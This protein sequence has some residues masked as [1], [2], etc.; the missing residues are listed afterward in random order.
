MERLLASV[1]ILLQNIDPLGDKLLVMTLSVALIATFTGAGA[2]VAPSDCA[3]SGGSASR[4]R[5]C[6]YS[7]NFHLE[8]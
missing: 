7:H 4:A 3:S 8:I 2:S 1:E 6:I 5:Y